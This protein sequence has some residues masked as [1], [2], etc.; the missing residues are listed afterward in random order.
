MTQVAIDDLYC[1]LNDVQL[2]M[3]LKKRKAA[4][5]KP[6]ANQRMIASLR[7]KV[8]NLKRKLEQ[9]FDDNSMYKESLVH[10]A[11]QERDNYKRQ[12]QYEHEELY[13]VKREKQELQEFVESRFPKGNGPMRCNIFGRRKF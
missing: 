5:Q 8:Q 11:K 2:L 6:S 10:G 13:R 9:S 4:E 1:E 3:D 7:D 12:L